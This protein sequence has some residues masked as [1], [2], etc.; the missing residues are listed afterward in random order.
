MTQTS[1]FDDDD[2]TAVGWGER[3]LRQL[4]AGDPW[5]EPVALLPGDPERCERRRP[6]GDP[7]YDKCDLTLDH[8]GD[9]AELAYADTEPRKRVR[10]LWAADPPGVR[11]QWLQYRQQTQS[12]IDTRTRYE[13]LLEDATLSDDAFDEALRRI[14]KTPIPTWEEWTQGQHRQPGP[15]MPELPDPRLHLVRSEDGLAPGLG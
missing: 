7:I 6:N 8:D 4:R 5:P 12:L 14:P 15:L 1:L 3:N 9:H 10:H 13:I 11:A 2:Q